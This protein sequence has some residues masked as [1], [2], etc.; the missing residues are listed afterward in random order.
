[1]KSGMFNDVEL[2]KKIEGTK[3]KGTKEDIRKRKEKSP[4][5]AG[6]YVELDEM[7]HAFCLDD[8]VFCV[9]LGFNEDISLNDIE[10]IERFAHEK[11]VQIELTPYS[12]QALLVI[13]QEKCYTL[14]HFLAVWVLDLKQWEPSNTRVNSGDVAV[15]EVTPDE[16]YD[17][18]RKLRR[19]SQPMGGRQKFQSIPQ[20]PFWICPI[21][22]HF[23]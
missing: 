22:K 17:W 4:L 8:S 3:I 16:S 9:G 12:C 15:L 13:L 19:G 18:A 6:D 20:R 23:C 10:V 2:A 1:M 14:D 7:G 11:S 21:Q 5:Y